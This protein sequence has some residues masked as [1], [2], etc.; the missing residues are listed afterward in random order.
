MH[1]LHLFHV[2]KETVVIFYY[3]I[4]SIISRLFFCILR[5]LHSYIFYRIKITELEMEKISR[6]CS[7]R[8]TSA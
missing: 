6:F 8:N 1:I 7:N 3:N 4:Y 5:F 2:S